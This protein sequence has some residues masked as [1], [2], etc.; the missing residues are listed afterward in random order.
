M[1][2]N[3]LEIGLQVGLTVGSLLIVYA[4]IALY[5]Q[6]VKLPQLYLSLES[7]VNGFFGQFVAKLQNMA[8]E[9]EDGG[10][11]EASG[12]EGVSL[13]AIGGFDINKI[14]QTVQT[15]GQIMKALKEMGIMGSGG[16]NL[17]LGGSGGGGGGKIGR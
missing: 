8:V 2:L 5:I 13:G 17:N 16:L 12:S 9:E 1:A 4:I 3:P 7:R 6:K 14:M 10:G 11:F 15:I